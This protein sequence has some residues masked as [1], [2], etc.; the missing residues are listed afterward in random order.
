MSL[1]NSRKLAWQLL[2]LLAPLGTAQPGSAI[3][4]TLGFAQCVDMALHQ[5]PDLIAS[6]AQIEQAEAALRQARGSRL[7]KLTASLTATRTNDALNAFG[8]KLSQRQASFNDFGFSQFDPAN[9]NLLNVKPDTLNYPGNVNNFN[10]RLE[11]QLP[12]YTG[13]MITGNIEQAKALIRAAQNGDIAARQK[14]IYQV[15]QAYQGV[16]S[17][18]AMVQVAKQAEI[19][20]NSQVKTI[21]SLV[22]GG[23]VVKSD[24]L[25]AQVRQQDTRIQ[26]LQAQNAEA[27]ALDQLHLLLGLPLNTPLDV[28]AAVMTPASTVSADDLQLQALSSNPGVQAQRSQV[29]A[30]QANVKVSK[31]NLYPQLGLLARQDWNDSKLGFAANSYTLAGTLSWTVFDGSVTQSAVD[32]ASAVRNEQAARLQQTENA[33]AADVAR[34]RRQSAEAEFSLTAREQAIESAE[35]ATRLVEKRYANG[36]ATITELL[37][38]QTQLD[39][40]RA[41]VVRAQYELAIQRASLLLALGQ[42]DPAQ[43]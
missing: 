10:T 38:A 17:A 2:I 22:K 19:A 6:R 23:V 41:D 12:I 20:A 36:V 21:T 29:E 7:P 13:G 8:I 31:A 3:A 37:A 16:H 14:L 40:A 18:R 30:A 39:K 32:R 24:L 26:L 1:L 9:P 5:N 15:L 34:A 35:Q 43:Y 27:S 11:A 33:V 25:S 42:L 4:G 28:G